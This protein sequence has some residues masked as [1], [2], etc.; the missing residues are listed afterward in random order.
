MVTLLSVHAGN[1]LAGLW[2]PTAL[3]AVGSVVGLMF[4]PETRN[5][6]LHA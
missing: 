6:D 1:V 4:L 3:L 2:Y 5:T